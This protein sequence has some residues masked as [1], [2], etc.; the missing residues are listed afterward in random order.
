MNKNQEI[1]SNYLGPREL[2]GLQKIGDIMIPRHDEF[3]SFSDTGCLTHVDDAVSQLD[4]IDL[5]DLK[6]F[7]KIASFLPTFMVKLVIKLLDW[8]PIALLRL[9]NLGV[10][11]IV[12]SLYYSNKT[13]PEYQGP[14]PHDIIGYHVK[15][16]P[17]E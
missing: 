16:V 12:Y 8:G 17:L 15:T 13:A 14:K 1:K 3:P 4:P 9:G 10:R 5:N 6:L 2:K 7:L 11:G